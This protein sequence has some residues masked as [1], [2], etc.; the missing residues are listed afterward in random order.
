MA[1]KFNKVF[2]VLPSG[3]NISCDSQL[4]YVK[5]V[6][7]TGRNIFSHAFTIKVEWNYVLILYKLDCHL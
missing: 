5:S 2:E 7:S 3:G 1:R 6:Q 4:N